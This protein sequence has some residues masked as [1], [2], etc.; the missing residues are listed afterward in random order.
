MRA[1]RT[2]AWA[3]LRTASTFVWYDRWAAEDR[4]LQG[5][6]RL[7]SLHPER[8]SSGELT[9]RQAENDD[10]AG[11]IEAVDVVSWVLLGLGASLVGTALGLFFGAPTEREGS[12]GSG[13]AFG[14]GAPSILE[15]SPW[16]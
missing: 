2:E 8:P 12:E 11:S 10:L 1:L 5:L 16:R 14:G 9:G 7:P 13:L 3:P 6:Y 15:V 4:T